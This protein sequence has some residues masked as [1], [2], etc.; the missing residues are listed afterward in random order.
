MT[1]SD[2]QQFIE[3]VDG[4]N[5]LRIQDDLGDGFVRLR[6][7]EAQRRQAKQDIRCTEDIVIET[8]RNARDAHASFYFL[9]TWKEQNKR[10]IT[11]LDN[12]DG[13]PEKLHETIFEP[14]VTSKL[15]TFHSDK[16]G[17]HGRGMA[18]YSI[19]ENA[20]LAKIVKS[21]PNRGSSFLVETDTTK[22]PEKT[23]QSSFPQIS[24]NDQGSPILRGPHNII[25]TVLEF[26]IEQRNAGVVYLGSPIEIAATLY[27]LSR[28]YSSL[29]ISPFSNEESLPL[30]CTLMMAEDPEDFTKRAKAIGL[31]LSSRS[32]R[33]IMND[34]IQPLDPHLSILTKGN[35]SEK[36]ESPSTS[37][38]SLHSLH[39]RRV[40]FEREDLEE[41]S[42]S[43]VKSYSDL[44]N[45][46]YLESSVEPSIKVGKDSITVIIPI[47]Y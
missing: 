26:A 45:K 35:S 43:V 9:A 46:Y 32:A 8:L 31:P 39:K 27:S 23:D 12:G 29:K 2:L 40:H 47:Q 11:I 28:V 17:V 41:F 10:F 6:A 4:E 3:E 16:W 24:H 37:R 33:R 30:I 42:R 5:H 15:D 20:L 21:Y 18:L 38:R 44:A 34:E 14:F 1:Q 19:R 36:R 25:R 7:A 22:L 13:V